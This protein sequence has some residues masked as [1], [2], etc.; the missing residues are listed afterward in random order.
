MR[1][2]LWPIALQRVERAVLAT[3]SRTTDRC[4]AYNRTNYFCAARAEE[5][6]V[7]MHILN[8]GSFPVLMLLGLV[9]SAVGC[10]AA[11]TPGPRGS[12]GSTSS[13]GSAG[14]TA[15]GSGGGTAG[16]STGSGGT[17]LIVTDATFVP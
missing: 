12:A 1:D 2:A 11:E 17:S 5:E 16:S 3:L 8:R 4:R 14:T 7:T 10:S 13:G 6:R 15:T 9:G